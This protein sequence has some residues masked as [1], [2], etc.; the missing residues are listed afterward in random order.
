M[1]DDESA[2]LSLGTGALA[3]APFGIAVLDSELRYRWVNRMMAQVNGVAA[4]AH[5]GRGIHEVI[6]A[7]ADDLL[8]VLKDVLHSGRAVRDLEIATGPLPLQPG[9]ARLW[10]MSFVP[11]PE[12]PGG[13]GVVLYAE[14][15]TDQRDAELAR[16]QSAFRTERFAALAAAVAA[17]VSVEQIADIVHDL[18]GA[19]LSA[20]ACGIALRDERD[21]LVFAGPAAVDGSGR[22]APMAGDAD[23][24]PAEV[25][26]SGQP[27]FL[28]HPDA[29]ASRWP[30]LGELQRSTGDQS[31]AVLPLTDDDTVIGVVAFAF[32]RRRSFWVEDRQYLTSIAALTSQALQRAYSHR[33]EHSIARTLQQALLPAAL[34]AIPGLRAACR[35]RAAS[36]SA[37]VGGDFY[38]LFS[39]DDG[40]AVAVI[41]DVCQGGLTAAA[42]VG[43]ARYALRAL[44]DTRQPA[45]ALRDLNSLLMHDDPHGRFL[46]AACLRIDIGAVVSVT[47]ANGGHPPPLVVNPRRGVRE[48]GAYG[49]L[50]G[51]FRRVTLR[52]RTEVIE[53]GSAIVLYTDGVIEAVGATGQYGEQRLTGLLRSAPTL[54]AEA[55][56]EHIL[57]DVT[58]FETRA[59]DDIALLVLTVGVDGAVP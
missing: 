26:R 47:I 21:M 10:R 53:P 37:D 35:Y 36:D 58:R 34:P 3:D 40:A 7:A 43:Q 23:M 59:R 38:D 41:G 25:L 50:I 29:L 27:L 31:W 33:R 39:V 13:P 28:P 48:L 19:A 51:A 9:R 30:Q 49:T 5:V 17:A 46:T 6:P 55:L 52:E 56:A 12:A 54:R 11:A 42:M 18:A 20:S 22:W 44:A 32:P 14:D 8:P 2:L 4:E 1:R 15:V 16:T 57:A 45:D 24:P